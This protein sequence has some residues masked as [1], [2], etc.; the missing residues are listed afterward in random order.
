MSTPFMQTVRSAGTVIVQDPHQ[1]GTGWRLLQSPTR[2]LRADSP[3]AVASVLAEVEAATGR[4]QTA[5]GFLTYEAARAF[6]PAC[7]VHASGPLPP[8]WFGL[9][10]SIAEIPPPPSC[11]PSPIPAWRPAESPDTYRANVVRIRDAIAAGDTYQVNYTFPWTADGIEDPYALFTDLLHWQPCGYAAYL[12][13]GDHVVCSLSPELFFR[14]EG[15]RITCRPMKGTVRRGVTTG[16]DARRARWLAQSEKN[17]AENLMIVDMIRNDLGR[18]ADP[19]TVRVGRLFDIE[20]Y[21]TLFQMTS[22]VTAQS[23]AS[24]PDLFKALFPCASITGAP[25]YR[26]M[27]I[28]RDLEPVPR[29]IYTGCIGI[30][31]P[32][33]KAMFNVA[34]RTMHVDRV[35]QVAT[36][37]T[38]GGIVW[39]SDPDDEYR[40]CKA[41][42]LVLRQPPPSVS[43]LETLRWEPASGY[44]F[45]PEHLC[46]L[47]DSA[48]YFVFPAARDK[49]VA[50]LRNAIPAE[51]RELPCRVRLHLDP[52]GSVQTQVTPL[53]EPFA[54]RPEDAGS[55]WRVARATEPVDIRDRF[56]YHK[57]TR[58]GLYDRA[59]ADRPDLDDALLWNTLGDVTESTIGN[60]AV[61]IG[62]YWITPPVSS[63]LLAGTFRARLLADGLLR[64]RRIGWAAV[65]A[66]ES[67]CL[68]N[69]VRGWI[70]AEL[71]ST[72]L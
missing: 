14:R 36:Y 39:D 50:A 61:R 12:N 60:L 4:G 52:D 8:A 66:A 26:T 29:G 63:G 44:L 30:V 47:L 54:W 1:T 53:E 3:E 58:R 2:V 11:R 46:R 24:L 23:Q 64:E 27:E 33:R 15:T 55:R 25:K 72:G 20:R 71:V 21:R 32:G 51:W 10:S 35:S 70:P 22:T 43:L 7:A 42:A 28:I 31:R 5:A 13:L 16:E 34:I 41:K 69:S 65:E 59:R 9:Y 62:G 67:L 6:D 48:R 45:L 19:G 68:L 37:S 18:I 38:G 49:V 17:R 57:T 40:E 56:L